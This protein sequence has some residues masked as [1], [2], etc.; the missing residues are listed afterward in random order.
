MN[1]VKVLQTVA[2]RRELNAKSRTCQTGSACY[3]CAL[4]SKS[5][6]FEYSLQFVAVFESWVVRRSLDSCSDSGQVATAQPRSSAIGLPWSTIGVG[7]P[8]KSLIN[9]CAASMPR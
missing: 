8:L 4:R 9:V 7:R 3:R 5:E 6:G 2:A 1:R